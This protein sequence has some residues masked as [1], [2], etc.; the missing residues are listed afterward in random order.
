MKAHLCGDD[1]LFKMVYSTKRTC[2]LWF[3]C[4]CGFAELHVKCYGKQRGDDLQGT[5]DQWLSNGSQG[6]N[7]MIRETL[8][9]S[10]L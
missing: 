3:F 5:L 1:L 7:F 6:S 8:T 2:A 9:R 4:A 10:F